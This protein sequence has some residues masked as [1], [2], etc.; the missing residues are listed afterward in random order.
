MK[1]LLPLIL[2]FILVAVPCFGQGLD[3]N[4]S[5]LTHADLDAT[6]ENVVDGALEVLDA[7]G[8]HVATQ[9]GD[10][11]IIPNIHKLGDSSLHSIAETAVPAS[12]TAITITDSAD[13]ILR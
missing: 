6:S 1:R 13:T 9:V 7:S 2:L 11:T 3:I 5:L 12:T 10:A 4:T 8:A